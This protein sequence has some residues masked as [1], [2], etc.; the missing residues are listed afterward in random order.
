MRAP[1]STLGDRRG[2]QEY[3]GHFAATGWNDPDQVDDGPGTAVILRVEMAQT[4]ARADR[5]GVRAVAQ[6]PESGDVAA[7]LQ[8]RPPDAQQLEDPAE[9]AG[10]RVGINAVLQHERD[11]HAGGVHTIE[12]AS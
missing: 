11:R 7:E 4:A 2:P 6:Q 12:Q 1:S 10:H 5:G 8:Y 9:R 3:P